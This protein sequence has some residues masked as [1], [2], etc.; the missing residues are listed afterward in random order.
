M[1]TVG[2]KVQ[3]ESNGQNSRWNELDSRHPHV[4]ESKQTIT[5]VMSVLSKP[6]QT[7]PLNS[8][9]GY[10]LIF[11]FFSHS[12]HHWLFTSQTT[13]FTIILIIIIFFFSLSNQTSHPPLS[14]PSHL[15]KM[16][17]KCFILY[18]FLKETQRR[19]HH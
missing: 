10:G 9:H 6:N 5:W 13:P 19:K 11:F 15:S 12:Q 7:K 18:F 3:Y 16:E 2:Y 8:S 4:H 17:N 1:S 14:Q